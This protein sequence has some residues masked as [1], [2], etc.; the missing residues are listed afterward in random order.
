[1]K[2]R[3]LSLYL[4]VIS[5]V[6]IPVLLVTLIHDTKNALNK[7]IVKN[8]SKT[9]IELQK[10]QMIETTVRISTPDNIF[11]SGTII[12]KEQIAS[13]VYRYFIITAKHVTSDRLVVGDLKI[14]SITGDV[15]RDLK[16][17][18]FQIFIFDECGNIIDSLKAQFLDE[19]SDYDLDCGL[20][21][22]DSENIYPVAN[23]ATNEILLNLD[24]L[25]D[26]YAVGCPLKH[27]P[28]ITTGTICEFNEEQNYI[29]STTNIAFGSSG[30]G[31]FIKQGDKYYLIGILF[32][33]EGY[34]NNLFSFLTRSCPIKSLDLFLTKNGI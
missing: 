21:Y 19:T 32:Q 17:E 11:G 16:E 6:S 27:I 24:I 14:D 34:R 23:I 29:L 15:S 13:N 22:F 4:I 33:I 25:Q 12:K 26:V 31:L 1:M 10:E 5:I 9:N 7:P 8:I 28:I 18:K 3:F 20:L 2:N 30:G